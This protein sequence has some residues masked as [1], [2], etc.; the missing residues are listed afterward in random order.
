MIERTE[1][2]CRS[3]HATIQCKINHHCSSWG[4]MITFL[5]SSMPGL[6][7]QM[8]DSPPSLDPFLSST[9]DLSSLI[10]SFSMLASQTGQWRLS[11]LRPCSHYQH[12]AVPQSPSST[13][14]VWCD[15]VMEDWFY[16]GREHR[17]SYMR[18]IIYAV[19][20]V[21]IFHTIDIFI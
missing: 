12:R 3:D 8:S 14:P 13:R 18:Y 10:Y 7:M 9:L 19:G 2:R 16:L 4:W 1:R 6:K 15:L 21:Y 11:W 17:N 5:Q 20:T